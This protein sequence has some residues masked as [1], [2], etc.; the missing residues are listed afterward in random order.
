MHVLG[1]HGALYPRKGLAS[2]DADKLNAQP[3]EQNWIRTHLI[4]PFPE[5][6]EV[7]LHM[8]DCHNKCKVVL[9]IIIGFAG[10]MISYR[11]APP[12]SCCDQTGP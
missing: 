1:L 2:T 4:R 3:C 9:E 7:K 12:K 5:P 10:A 6:Q 11:E 8:Q